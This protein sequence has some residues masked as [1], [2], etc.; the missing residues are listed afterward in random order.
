VRIADD[1]EVLVRGPQVAEAVVG[2]ADGPLAPGGW[3]HT[4]DLGAITPDGDLMIIGRKK[5][6]IVTSYGKN[7]HPAGIEARIREI[8][9]VA[10]VLLLGDRKPYVSA[11]LWLRDLSTTSGALAELDEAVRR[12]NDGLARAE[13]VKRWAV[14]AEPSRSSGA[15]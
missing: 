10:E 6:I 11:L 13:R 4:G 5:E 12:Q 2:Y 9:G 15:S 14:L 3:L 8:P 7:I 1:A